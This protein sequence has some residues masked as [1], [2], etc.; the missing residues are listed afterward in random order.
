MAD[1]DL[2][3]DEP[4]D[5]GLDVESGQRWVSELEGLETE[6]H[7]VRGYLVRARQLL[8]E[9]QELAPLP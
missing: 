8:S 2:I 5:A 3:I 7:D 6:G 9:A 1:L 4:W